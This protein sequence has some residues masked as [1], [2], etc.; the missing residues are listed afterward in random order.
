V[1][2]VTTIT[3]NRN[4]ILGVATRRGIALSPAGC[5]VRR[6]WLMVPE[7]FAGVVIDQFVVM[8]N[9]VH[10]IVVLLRR[11]ERTASL[12]LVVGWTKQRATL[13]I[14]AQVPTGGAPIWQRSFHDR[15]IRDRDALAR[16]RNYINANPSHAW[17]AGRLR[18]RPAETRA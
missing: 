10:A 8:P 4:P 15:I 18:S 16:V 5:T 12:S 3:H 1:Y 14:R 11:P 6:C 17:R 9:H 7:Q 2:F 13:D